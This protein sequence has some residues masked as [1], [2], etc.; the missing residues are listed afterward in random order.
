MPLLKCDPNKIYNFSSDSLGHNSH[1]K[2][3][4]QK[5]SGSTDKYKKDKSFE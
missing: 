3:R 2:K 5:P 1:D 4:K